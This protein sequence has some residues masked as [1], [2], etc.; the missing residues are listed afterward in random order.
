M[1]ES[2]KR[3]SALITA[4][5]LG[6]ALTFSVP[7]N[8]PAAAEEVTP[9]TPVI[10]LPPPDVYWSYLYYAW[11]YGTGPGMMEAGGFGPAM[12]A[13]MASHVDGRLAYLKAELMITEA[14]EP[15]WKDYAAAFRD[16]AKGMLV[17]C[18]KMMGSRGAA[19]LSLP[20]R[21][22]QHEQLMAAQLDAV[23]AA[24]KALKPLYASFS[25]NQ[26]KTVDQM[27]WGPMGMM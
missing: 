20:D 21:M 18:K 19:A 13:M 4:G 5:M 1:E 14:Q 9:L 12:C 25:E 16:N 3:F 27:F 7:S 26:K 22:D 24:N 8:L 23:R 11:G 6:A 15:L 10:P 17:R 2:V